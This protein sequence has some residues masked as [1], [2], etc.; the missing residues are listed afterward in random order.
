M[1]ARASSPGYLRAKS[2]VGD[3][4][5][6]KRRCEAFNLAF[7]LLGG[8]RAANHFLDAMNPS[9]AGVPRM[10]ADSSPLGLVEVTRVLRRAALDA[11]PAEWLR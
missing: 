11:A 10:R 9:L 6:L 2:C 7:L 8:R 4:P 3:V 1:R 5:S